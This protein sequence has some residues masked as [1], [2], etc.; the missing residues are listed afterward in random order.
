MFHHEVTPN[1]HQRLGCGDSE[2]PVSLRFERLVTFGPV[3][4]YNLKETW[5]DE[6]RELY[7]RLEGGDV[8]A[9][10]PLIAIDLEFLTD[11]QAMCILVLLKFD[12]ERDTRQAKLELRKIANIIERRPAR[13]GQLP[14]GD[15][16]FWRLKD[17]AEMINNAGLLAV[18]RDPA[19]LEEKVEE[20]LGLGPPKPESAQ[21]DVRRWKKAILRGVR[22]GMSYVR[23]SRSWGLNA[24]EHYYGFDRKMI[25]KRISR[26]PIVRA[27]KRNPPRG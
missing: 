20:C 7:K 23:S 18:R 5:T 16:L 1:P 22:I 8:T 6:V 13:R 17:L 24:L 10:A 12:P 2:T 19:A 11:S 21:R 15:F 9:L 25:E 3:V 4:N 26:D 27:M 14:A